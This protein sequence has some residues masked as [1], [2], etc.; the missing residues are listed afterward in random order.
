M[1]THILVLVVFCYVNV[2][3]F[4]LSSD[5]SSLD[6]VNRML[7]WEVTNASV[8]SQRVL[9]CVDSDCAAVEIADNT[10]WLLLA[11]PGCSWLA[12]PGFRTNR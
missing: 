2:V 12:A 5:R 9:S 4:S 6:G 10:S 1:K 8:P 3:M 7:M 11:A